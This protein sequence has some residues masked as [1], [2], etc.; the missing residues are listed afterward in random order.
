MRQVIHLGSRPGCV[1]GRWAVPCRGALS[2]VGH[3][4]PRSPPSDLLQCL[5]SGAQSRRRGKRECPGWGHRDTPEEGEEGAQGLQG[6]LPR[7]SALLRPGHPWTSHLSP[8]PCSRSTHAPRCPRGQDTRPS[9][10][11]RPALYCPPTSVFCPGI[12]AS[13]PG[14]MNPPHVALRETHPAGALSTWGSSGP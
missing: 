9:P 11:H 10:S 8:R 12:L 7:L 4:A 5:T 14:P 6:L 2:S 13:V 3:L 1:P